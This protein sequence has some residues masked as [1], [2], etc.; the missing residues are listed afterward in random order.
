MIF[1]LMLLLKDGRNSI[2]NLVLALC[3]YLWKGYSLW[4]FLQFVV[5][6]I[7]LKFEII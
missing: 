7:L 5:L 4:Y 3:Y 1:H 2:L 6:T